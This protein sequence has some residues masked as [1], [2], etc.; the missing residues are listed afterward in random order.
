MND[1]TTPYPLHV[2]PNPYPILTPLNPNPR[3]TLGGNLNLVFTDD[4]PIKSLKVYNL[5]Y[6]LLRAS[7][8]QPLNATITTRQGGCAYDNMFSI[9]AAMRE[10]RDLVGGL[11]MEVRARFNHHMDAIQHI[12]THHLFSPASF[13]VRT[14][15]RTITV[16]EYLQDAS[17]LFRKARQ[18]LAANNVMRHDVNRELTIREKAI[19]GDLKLLLGYRHAGFKSDPTLGP[20][21]W[22]DRN[23]AP[24]IP[25]QIPPPRRPP[26][27]I[28]NLDS[29]DEE[30]PPADNQPPP[31]PPPTNLNNALIILARNN[32]SDVGNHA[33]RWQ[34]VHR[35]FTMRYPEVNSTSEQL[36]NRVR[37]LRKKNPNLLE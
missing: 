31:R 24:P 36:R 14:S 9:L 5:Q 8:S 30:Q 13:E 17:R 3:V 28:I 34:E 7:N 26:Q 15:C 2:T 22:L 19:L 23:P 12:L 6:H 35:L 29:D 1:S 16:A 20:I 33:I 11:R 21:W 4:G 37:H 32:R 18:I 25:P 27:P 10:A